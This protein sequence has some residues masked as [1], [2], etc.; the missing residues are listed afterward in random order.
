MEDVRRECVLKK[1]LRTASV[2][3]EGAPDAVPVTLEA[4]V[5]P[6]WGTWTL[7]KPLS[8]V[9]SFCAT[10][11]GPRVLDEAMPGLRHVENQPPPSIERA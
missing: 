10:H 4:A 2:L 1:L 9:C 8:R 5:A 11:L 3:N 6:A 7:P